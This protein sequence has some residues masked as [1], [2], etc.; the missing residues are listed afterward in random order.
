MAIQIEEDPL[1]P[2]KFDIPSNIVVLPA[3]L[4]QLPLTELNRVGI[5]VPTPVILESPVTPLNSRELKRR[6]AIRL[7]EIVSEGDPIQNLDE[8]IELFLYEGYLNDNRVLNEQS[9]QTDEPLREKIIPYP[10]PILARRLVTL[11]FILQWV[12]F[13]VILSGYRK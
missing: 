12:N 8:Y 10:L 2:S 13:L 4:Q 6:L 9:V 11:I 1:W 7:A 5:H 3:N